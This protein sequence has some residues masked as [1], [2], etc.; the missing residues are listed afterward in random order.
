MNA[1]LEGALLALALIAAGGSTSFAGSPAKA[2]IGELQVS[3]DGE[4]VSVSF[5]VEQAVGDDTLAKIESGLVVEQRHRIE[6]IARRSVPL[7]TGKAI[8]KLRVDTSAVYDTLTRRF[9]LLR[10]TRVWPGETG[11][12]SVVAEESHSTT[13]PEEVREWMSVFDSL[14][15]LELP[16]AAGDA[17]LKLRVESTLGRRFVWYLFP[18]KLTASAEQ[19]LD[20]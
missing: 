13:S 2:R 14:P 11:K 3:S 1:R 9:D 17:R 4:R 18:S 16:A 12:W 20:R 8:A 5:R 15:A 19:K 7:W 10:T 6:V